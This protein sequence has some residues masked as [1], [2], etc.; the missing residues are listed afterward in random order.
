MAEASLSMSR[1]RVRPIFF[2]GDGDKLELW[3]QLQPQIFEADFQRAAGVHLQT[4]DAA[5]RDF[6]IVQVH[7]KLSVYGR[8]DFA[9]D[10]QNLIDVPV[11]SFDAGFAGFVGQERATVFLI[12]LA[13]PTGADVGLRALHFKIAEAF[14]AELDAAVF[15][16][17]D[18]LH[19]QDEPK[20]VQRQLAFQELV[21]LEAGRGTADDFAVFDRPQGPITIPAGQVFAVE[22][23][24]GG[25]RA[26]GQRR[27]GRPAQIVDQ[28]AH[29]LVGESLNEALRHHRKLALGERLD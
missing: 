24:R 16:V 2:L 25:F 9:A 15:L 10:R 3:I 13:P 29:F 5:A 28:V 26:G 19:F 21:V 6:W 1:P 17:R 11:V 18:E 8:A 20:I 7:A 12:E 23:Y 4:D 27:L 14:A 22:K